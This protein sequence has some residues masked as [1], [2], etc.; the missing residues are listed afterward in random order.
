MLYLHNIF[1]RSVLISI[2]AE[3]TSNTLEIYMYILIDDHF[4][5]NYLDTCIIYTVY[6]LYMCI[7]A[8]NNDI[9]YYNI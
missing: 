1:M 9:Y 5:S 2:H 3:H 4:I 8:N 6:T 7:H